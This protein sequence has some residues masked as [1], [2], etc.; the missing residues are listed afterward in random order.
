MNICIDAGHGGTDPGAIGMTPFRLEERT[1]N[2][3]VA[4]IM[5]QLLESMGHNVLMTRKS[6][7]TLSLA[8]RARFAN[9]Y[10]ADLFV[11]IH[12]NAAGSPQAEGMEV[13]HFPGSASGAVGAGKVLDRMLRRFPD[14]KNRGVKEANFAVLRLTHMPAI[15]V[16]CEFLTNPEQLVFLA[17]NQEGL[18]H[19]I[20]EGVAEWIAA[21]S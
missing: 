10:E 13:F 16:E 3:D 2:L 15:L 20:A 21:L 14:H 4:L 1:V 17:E 19:A 8:A 6:D 7:R 18:A 12:S 11:S 5:E 9:R